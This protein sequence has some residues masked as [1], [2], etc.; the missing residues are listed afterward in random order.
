[1]VCVPYIHHDRL[2]FYSSNCRNSWESLVKILGSILI[3]L[4]PQGLELAN[5]Q[6][7]I[8]C[9]ALLATV[10][11]G[12]LLA[13]FSLVCSAETS[14]E[15]TLTG[16]ISQENICRNCAAI[17]HYTG[18]LYIWYGLNGQTTHK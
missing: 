2:D 3:N 9:A 4:C 16:G 5:S 6:K 14:L 18:T 12:Y 7:E 15:I 10:T 17:L 11:R 8:C 13:T 1:M